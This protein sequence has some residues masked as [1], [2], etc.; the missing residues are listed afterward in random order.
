MQVSSLLV[1]P[2]RATDCLSLSDLSDQVLMEMLIER[3]D[4]GPSDQF[5]DKT[6]AYKEVCKWPGVQCNGRRRVRHVRWMDRFLKQTP[7]AGTLDLRYIPPLTRN[8]VVHTSDK[9][10]RSTISGTVDTAALPRSLS[11]FFIPYQQF[12]GTFDFRR[13]P[14]ELE[15]LR[16]HDNRFDGSMLVNSLPSRLETFHAA[17]NCFSG[18]ILL[19]KL[20][21]TL[22]Y[23]D[24]SHNQLSGSLCLC[25]LPLV[26]ETL[27]LDNNSFTGS[28]S[29]DSLPDGLKLIDLCSNSLRG[30]F[31]LLRPPSAL[32]E[33][34]VQN[35]QF[36]G[37]AIIARR[38]HASVALLG[39]D[40]KHAIDEYG[41]DCEIPD[42]H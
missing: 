26:L 12:F 14:S 24:A 5:R 6:G 7:L 1:I 2:D 23:L 35:N 15:I 28:V 31:V 40:V 18:N 3:M 29:F 11:G 34:N 20:P 27:L 16:I 41:I 22:A 37:T 9:E 30:K 32:E 25:S 33:I 42:L 8:F 36:F 17:W 19:T 10:S 4:K 39:N 21:D 38:A 13:L